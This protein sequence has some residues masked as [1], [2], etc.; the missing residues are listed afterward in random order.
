[1]SKALTL[2]GI[3]KIKPATARREIP[4]A[5]CPG[6]YLVVQ[7]S[8][9]K[10][11]VVRYR[12]N[13]RPRK[14]TLGRYPTIRLGET[15][16]EAKARLAKNPKSQSA[17]A[18]ELARAALRAVALGEDP[19]AEK[20]EARR[21]EQAG[22]TKSDL[23]GA[24][25][26]EYKERH[27]PSLRKSTSHEIER[28]FNKRILPRWRKRRMA[29]I[30][31]RD[32]L[33]L[34]DSMITDGAPISANRMIAA[35]SHFFNWAVQRDIIE[36]SP[37]VGI[38]KPT[39]QK[40]RDRVLSDDELRW[41]WL[42]ADGI[43][44]PFGPVVKLLILTGARR[45]EITNMRDSELLLD[46]CLFVIPVNR[47]K[48]GV[49]H[50]IH[51]SDLALDIVQ[52]LPRIKSKHGLKFTTTGETPISGL[53]RAKITLDKLMLKHAKKESRDKSADIS[54]PP[55]VYHD[56]RR[57]MASGMARL[58]V[59]L[60]VIERALNHISGSFG[61]VQGIYQRHSFADEKVAAFE[62]WSRH[63][64]H[65]LGAKDESVA[66]LQRQKRSSA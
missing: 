17:D 55:W 5:H 24:V 43:G 14:H 41:L 10:S 15:K 49:Q 39:P 50:E 33:A 48:N 61:G 38:K 56:L 29:E 40:S 7:P 35:V 20:A 37:C 34:A 60:P 63:I 16:E 58:G 19:Q 66:P 32:V 9:S 31:K 51:L 27:F 3:E 12:F 44:W 62:K 28:L 6:L 21:Q 59:H 23:L 36:Y 25:F 57:S 65:V 54:V 1:M 64:E 4:D 46:K 42:A 47:S 45:S 30:K 52:S 18:R 26:E 11:W 2:A 8:G 22:L 13:G 53:S